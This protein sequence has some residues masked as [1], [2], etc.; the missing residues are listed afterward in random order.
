MANKRDRSQSFQVKDENH[1]ARSFPE[2]GAVAPC[3]E[4]PAQTEETTLSN[5]RVS[6]IR[7]QDYWTDEPFRPHSVIHSMGG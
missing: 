4:T 3:A 5:R 6:V 7:N 2:R 1:E